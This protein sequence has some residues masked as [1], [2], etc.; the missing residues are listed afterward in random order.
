MSGSSLSSSG[1]PPSS[2]TVEFFS[3]WKQPLTSLTV[4]FLL[5]IRQIFI[6][7]T[8]TYTFSNIDLNIC[9]ENICF[10]NTH[11]T[12]LSATEK[13]IRFEVYI[14]KCVYTMQ[15]CRIWRKNH[16]QKS[17]RLF[18]VTEKFH[19]FGRRWLPQGW[20]RRPT[21]VLSIPFWIHILY[22][23]NSGL[24]ESIK[25]SRYKIFKRPFVGT[26]C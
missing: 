5:Q 9:N 20:K 14:W 15:I 18:S 13:I 2:K 4:F 12:P 8:H 1:E 6:V 24:K 19:R 22:Q 21:H 11:H 26:F 17:Q 16:G 7:Y 25:R 10:G 3:H 23:C